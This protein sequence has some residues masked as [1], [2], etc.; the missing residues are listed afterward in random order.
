ME[1]RLWLDILNTLFHLLFFK[2]A[3]PALFFVYFRSFQT[4]ITTIFTTNQCEKCT[5]SIWQWDSNPR[6]FEQESSPITTRPGLPPFHL[7]FDYCCKIVSFSFSGVKLKYLHLLNCTFYF[8]KIKM[9]INNSF[10]RG[11][12]AS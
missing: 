8:S 10:T 2:W 9:P 12:L 6:P 7:L 5:S 11:A 4:N 3:N 1:R